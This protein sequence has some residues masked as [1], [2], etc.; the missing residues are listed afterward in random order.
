MSSNCAVMP[1][2]FV[3]VK[4]VKYLRLEDVTEILLEFAGSEETDVRNRMHELVQCL[5]DS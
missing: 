4:E 3:M 2:R 1:I 5:K